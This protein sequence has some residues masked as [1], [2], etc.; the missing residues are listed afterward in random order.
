MRTD[1]CIQCVCVCVCVCV[2]DLMLFHFQEEFFQIKYFNLHRLSAASQTSGIL[3]VDNKYT[4]TKI[5]LVCTPCQY[6]Y[7][8]KANLGV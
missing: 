2:R 3:V 5:K 1:D 7:R 8:Y 6:V 4:E